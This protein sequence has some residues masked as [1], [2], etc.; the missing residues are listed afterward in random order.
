MALA[1]LIRLDLMRLAEH[2]QA[3][4]KA[5]DPHPGPLP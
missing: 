1:E 3:Q 2:C 4:K 5:E